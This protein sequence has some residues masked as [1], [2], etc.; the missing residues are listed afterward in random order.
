MTLTVSV[1]CS[2]PAWPRRSG[3]TARRRT[4][5]SAAARWLARGGRVDDAPSRC[6]TR[7]RKGRGDGSWCGRR[8]IGW[9]KAGAR[10][11]GGELLGFYHSHP[12]HPA[13]PSQFDLDHAWPT[14]AYVI[15]AVAPGA[16]G[17]MTVWFLKDDRS[18]FEEGDAAMATKI[19]IPTPL[20]PYTDKK[21]AVEAEGATVG[22]LLADLTSK[23]TGLK[24]APVQRAGEAAQLRQRLR[25]RRRHP[26]SAEGT[27]AGV[28]RRTRSASFRRWRAA[29]SRRRLARYG[30][31]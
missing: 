12:D 30:E 5:T 29:C 31:P 28:G 8:I 26:V 27:D 9:R 4:R 23:H 25:E 7:P 16:A 21:D 6:R 14:F 20:R 10:E 3:G 17:D 24:A 15:V 13:R 1:A 11:L 18:S 22:E 2:T 19:L